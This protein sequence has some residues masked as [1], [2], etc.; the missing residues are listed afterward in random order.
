MIKILLF[1][2]LLLGLL[3]GPMYAMELTEVKSSDQLARYIYQMATQDVWASKLLAGI[4]SLEMLKIP[5]YKSGIPVREIFGTIV[6]ERFRDDIDGQLFEKSKK[7][8]VREIC[9]FRDSD[10]I[11]WRFHITIFED[12]QYKVMKDFLET[13]MKDKK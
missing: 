6:E 3:A 5:E 11:V 1:I 4:E 8:D 12:R 2:P 13:L 10:D 7:Y 9:A